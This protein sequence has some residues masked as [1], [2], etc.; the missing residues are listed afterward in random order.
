MPAAPFSGGRRRGMH[1][2]WED[3]VSGSGGDAWLFAAPLLRIPSRL[4]AGG[5]LQ[6][7]MQS[8]LLDEKMG[9][10]SLCPRYHE[11]KTYLSKFPDSRFYQCDNLL[12]E[13]ESVCQQG[14]KFDSLHVCCRSGKRKETA[15]LGLARRGAPGWP[16][17]KISM[18]LPGHAQ[19]CMKFEQNHVLPFCQP[20]TFHLQFAPS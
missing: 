3:G 17:A 19:L 13:F 11:H 2:G 4:V 10:E 12:P 8:R 15:G 7:L 14:V 5:V 20:R 6:P 18:A 16:A 9:Y 1:G